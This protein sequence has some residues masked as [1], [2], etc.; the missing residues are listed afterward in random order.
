MT[1]AER[2]FIPFTQRTNLAQFVR[3][4]IVGGVGF[5]VDSGV[6]LALV[7]TLGMD[8][9]LAR[10]LSYT[11]AVMAT[12]ALNRVWAFRSH[13][14]IL[15]GL[16]LYLVVQSLGFVCNLSIYSALYVFVAPPW[17]APLACLAIASCLALVVNYVGAKLIVFRTLA[18]RRQA[19][20]IPN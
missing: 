9:V 16:G 1:G 5:C 12:Y 6:L 4:S 20:A 17:N 13:V 3:F 2:V 8:P 19:G 18:P 14:G 10:L 7:R 15:R 11:A